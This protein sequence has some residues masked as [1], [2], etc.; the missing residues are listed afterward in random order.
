MSS[1]TTEKFT[2]NAGII[3]RRGPMREIRYMLL[4]QNRPSARLGKSF[5]SPSL[6]IF[7]ER[8][9]KPD[10]QSEALAR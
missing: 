1:R 5:R 2:I 6:A 4:G 8:I 3:A 10:M 9:F 7:F